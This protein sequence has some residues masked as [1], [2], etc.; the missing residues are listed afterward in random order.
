MA[1]YGASRDGFQAR[2]SVTVWLRRHA[3]PI[4]L[5]SA[6]AR[7]FWLPCGYTSLNWAGSGRILYLEL[8][9]VLVEPLSRA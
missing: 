4:F 9:C 7:L 5:D 8:Q 3:S 1:I 2:A 6:M